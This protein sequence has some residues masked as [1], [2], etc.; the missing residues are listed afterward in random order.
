MYNGNKRFKEIQNS[1]PKITN[2]VLSKELK[3]L[4][5]NKLITR[6]VYGTTPVTIEYEA[7]GY[8]MRLKP[9][10]QKMTDWGKN[11]RKMIAGKYI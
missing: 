5:I 9:I 1:I 3:D 6:S 8:C 11:H 7:T 10:I 2:R 4:E